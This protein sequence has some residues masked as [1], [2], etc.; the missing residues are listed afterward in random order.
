MYSYILGFGN[1]VLA[2]MPIKL[3]CVSLMSF[4]DTMMSGMKDETWRET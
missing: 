1:I 4:I 3:V 2:A